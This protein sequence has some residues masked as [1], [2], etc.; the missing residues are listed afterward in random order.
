ML[1]EAKG[2]LEVAAEQVRK[3]HCHRLLL[4]KLDTQPRSNLVM[5]VC[6]Q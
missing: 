4:L 6:V 2:D 5:E 3:V 1:E